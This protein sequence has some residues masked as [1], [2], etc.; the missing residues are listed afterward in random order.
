MLQPDGHQDQPHG[1][2]VETEQFTVRQ[3]DEIHMTVDANPVD[4]ERRAIKTN[5][6][7]AGPWCMKYPLRRRIVAQGNRNK[8]RRQPELTRAW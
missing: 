5:A 6:F 2:P 1:L 7:F 4:V 8:A 3:L